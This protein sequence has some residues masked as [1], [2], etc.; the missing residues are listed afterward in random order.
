[1]HLISLCSGT[2][3]ES[4]CYLQ[5]CHFE[6]LFNVIGTSGMILISK[7]ATKHMKLI[8]TSTYIGGPSYGAN[9]RTDCQ[10]F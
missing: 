10:F 8:V 4:N 5:R 3:S 2:L 6:A 1:M 7:E 9:H